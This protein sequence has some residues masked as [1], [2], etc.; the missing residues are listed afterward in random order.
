MRRSLLVLTIACAVLGLAV[1]TA[2]AERGDTMR[3]EFAPLEENTD[4][5]IAGHAA[6]TRTGQGRTHLSV[7][8]EGLEPDAHHHGHLHEGACAD[9]GPH[10]QHDPEGAEEPPNELWPSSDPQDATAGL[11]SNP[12]G[13]ANGRGTAPWRARD[14]ALSVFI[15]DHHGAKIACADLGS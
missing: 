3:G 10:Y 11:H 14:E 9:V 2:G 5:D 4:R 13:N 8:L 15:H 6:L 1:A 12:A 7:Q